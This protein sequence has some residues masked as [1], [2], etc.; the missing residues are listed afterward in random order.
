MIKKVQK[1]LIAGHECT[2][3]PTTLRGPNMALL[4]PLFRWYLLRMPM[5]NILGSASGCVSLSRFYTQESTEC[6]E[7]H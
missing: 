5:I 4:I 1:A 7:N 6:W 3:T 2:P